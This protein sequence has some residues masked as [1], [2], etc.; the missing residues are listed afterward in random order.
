MTNISLSGEDT[1]LLVQALSTIAKKVLSPNA[2]EFER[3][4]RLI[5]SALDS[6]Y[7]Q[8][9]TNELSENMSRDDAEFLV[10]TLT[11]IAEKVL[12]PDVFAKCVFTFLDDG[13]GI[14]ITAPV[15]IH[16]HADILYWTLLD[17]ASRKKHD[18][19]ERMRST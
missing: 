3:L 13:F 14:G 4:K 15:V 1:A 8:V 18:G 10:R 16:W 7:T 19:D 17:A 9:I 11:A 12:S 6:H 5:A 2:S